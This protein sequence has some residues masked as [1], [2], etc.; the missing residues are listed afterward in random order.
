M[1]GAIL[2]QLPPGRLRQLYQQGQ[3]V[4]TH[5][6]EVRF[7]AFHQRASI[8]T[9]GLGA[10]STMIISSEHGAILAHIAPQPYPTTDT[11][12]AEGYVRRMMGQ[13]RQQYDHWRA[14]GY[15]P[16]AGSTIVCALFRNERLGLPSQVQIMR[17]GMEEMGF[18]DPNM[19]GYYVPTDPHGPGQG[20]VVVLS[21]G[22]GRSPMVFVQDQEIGTI[23]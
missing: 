11:Q 16:S 8:G 18:N 9:F 2:R 19:I 17:H 7:V 20:T 23:H 6:H 10:C 5:M 21:R 4:M 22:A 1:D 13:V 3:A 15:F 14:Q 12:V